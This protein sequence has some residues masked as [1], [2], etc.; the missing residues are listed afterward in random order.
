MSGARPLWP[1][2]PGRSEQVVTG[3]RPSAGPGDNRLR[4]PSRNPLRCGS[5]GLVMPSLDPGQRAG[6]PK[7]GFPAEAA[8]VSAG[9][10]RECGCAG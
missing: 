3:G 9:D 1:L 2:A 6:S 7:G 8:L 10:E 4:H 5:S